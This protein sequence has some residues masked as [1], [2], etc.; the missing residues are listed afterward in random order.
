MYYKIDFNRHRLKVLFTCFLFG[1]LNACVEPYDFKSETYE[2]LLVVEG[3]IT[4]ELKYQEIYLSYVYK[5]D[6]DTIIPE[7]NAK[8][9]VIDDAQNEFE[10][11]ESEPGKYESVNEFRITPDKKYHLEITTSNGRSYSSEEETLPENNAVMNDLYAE[12]AVNNQGVKGIAIYSSSTNTGNDGISYYKYTYIETYKIVSPYVS[13]RDFSLTNSG[14]LELIPKTREEEI[15]YNTRRSNEILLADTGSLSEN[16]ISGF[17][18]KFFS[19]DD[20]AIQN[21]YSIVVNQISISQEAYDYYETLKELSGSES[22]FSQ[23]QP[24][25]IKGNIYSIDDS[26]EKV[27]GNFNLAKSSSKRIFFNFTDFF[28]LNEKPD[29]TRFCDITRPEYRNLVQLVIND[30]VKFYDETYGAPPNEEG[31]GPFRVLPT[32]CIDCT[33][34]GASEKPEFWI[35]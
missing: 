35:E 14:F 8:V 25:F 15:C 7:S 12:R 23:N 27:I 30:Q 11:R 26:N 33:V 10:F 31:E 22:V 34:L 17:L 32:Y 19:F 24:G 4:N 29:P 9:S 2:K 13:N 6:N 3:S 18:V 5:I 28:S 1:I 21:R 20:F 16:E